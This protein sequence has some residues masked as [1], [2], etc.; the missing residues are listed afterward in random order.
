METTTTLRVPFIVS[1]LRYN[2]SAYTATLCDYG[3]FFT[4]ITAFGVYYPVA[5]FCGSTIGATIAFLLGRNWTF[6]NKEELITRQSIKFLCV[7]IGSIFLNTLGVYMV[8]EYLVIDEKIS[9]I[10]VGIFI[11]VCYN[12][13]LQRYFVFK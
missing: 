11:G 9:K 3:I 4:L 10:L 13:P 5:T 8:T 12:F 1:F 6:R 7:V 2:A